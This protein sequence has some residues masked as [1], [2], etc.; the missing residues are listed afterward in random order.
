MAMGYWCRGKENS[1][2]F[3]AINK[4]KRR[5]LLG[6][7]AEGITNDRNLLGG[8]APR[9]EQHRNTRMAFRTINKEKSGDLLGE[10][11]ESLTNDRNLLGEKAPRSE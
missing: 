11:A 2:V 5:D 4:Q 8:K 9:P 7:Y 1:N 10:Y 6:E 3:E